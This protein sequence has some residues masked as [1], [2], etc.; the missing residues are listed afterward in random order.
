MVPSA[1]RRTLNGN[2][3]V[4]I[5]VGRGSVGRDDGAR[6]RLSFQKE[7]RLRQPQFEGLSVR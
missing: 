6:R 7:R 1:S 5:G 4:V 3:V 2:A